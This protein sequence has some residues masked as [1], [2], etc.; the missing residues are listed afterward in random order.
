MTPTW[1]GYLLDPSSYVGDQGI[2][3]LLL[4]HLE[5]SGLALICTIA[6]A[7]PAGLY[8]GHKRRG[9]FLVV[10]LANAGRAIPA[11]GIIVL[12]AVTVW[13]VNLLTLTITLVIFAIPQVLTNTYTGI[14]GAD[15][16]VVE[17]AR[18]IGMSETRILF[19]I[20]LP[21]AANLIASGIRSAAVQI[22]AVATIAA[23]AGAGGLGLIIFKGYDSSIL[24]YQVDGALLVVILALLVQFAFG[25]VQ[26]YSTPKGL[27]VVRR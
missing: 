18:G 20:E 9:N 3:Q 14:A 4:Q 17:A 16:S 2:L 11:F 8:L 24:A 13:G 25:V 6:I 10:G 27:R 12:F 7:L 1:W 21:L 15:E 26:H 22:V 5:Y 23:Y 19:G